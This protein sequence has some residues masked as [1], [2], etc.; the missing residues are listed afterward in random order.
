MIKGLDDVDL[1][2]NAAGP[3]LH[4]A[5]PLVEACLHSGTH[6]LDISNELQ[7]FRTLY[8]LNPWAE[9]ASITVIPGVG[10]GVVATNCLARSVSDAVGGAETLEVVARVTSAQPGPGVAAT[11]ALSSFPS[12]AGSDRAVTSVAQEIG[13]GITTLSFPDGE[14]PIMP[15]PTGDLE[16]GFQATGAPNVVA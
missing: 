3:F 5:A 7:V 11:R 12:E 13:S 4:T 15:V 14:F 9:Q 6:Y 2:L 1:V 8:D 16:A 10:F